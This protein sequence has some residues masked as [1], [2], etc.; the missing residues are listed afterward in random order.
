MAKRAAL[1]AA[2]TQTPTTAPDKRRWWRRS[3]FEDRGSNEDACRFRASRDGSTNVPPRSNPRPPL[4]PSPGK[5]EHST[6]FELLTARISAF[7]PRLPPHS[8]SRSRAASPSAG[9]HRPDSSRHLDLHLV[10]V[11][12]AAACR[13]T[14][15]PAS[16]TRSRAPRGRAA[17]TRTEARPSRCPSS[18]PPSGATPRR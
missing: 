7:P 3:G 11:D 10:E 18:S 16:G 17:G 2:T 9:L 13:G 6:V 8:S 5:F 14:S 4:P 12:V 15:S 1:P